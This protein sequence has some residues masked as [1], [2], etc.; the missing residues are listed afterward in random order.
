MGLFSCE[1]RDGRPQAAPE[2]RK[3]DG[4][5]QQAAGTGE[6]SDED[7]M[8]SHD[9]RRLPHEHTPEEMDK[10]FPR[11]MPVE[12]RHADADFESEIVERMKLLAGDARRPGFA[13]CLH[14]PA[15]C[16]ALWFR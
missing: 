7:N 8:P 13:L 3:Q 16:L 14:F 9:P 1:Y 5:I 12:D 10:F 15:P 11:A 2:L 4:T 6:L